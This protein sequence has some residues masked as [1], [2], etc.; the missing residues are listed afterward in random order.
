MKLFPVSL[1]SNQFCKMCGTCARNC[2]Y[3]S[4]HLD[5]RWPGAEIW[6]N[7]E[8]NL[9]TSL[10]IPAFLGILFPLFVHEKLHSHPIGDLSFT[11]IYLASVLG[12]VVLFM[13][14]SLSEGLSNFRSQIRA[15]GFSYLPLA[16]AGHLALLLPY[17]VSG[18]R[19]L[20]SFSLSGEF[21]HE[22]TSPWPQRLILAVGILWSVWALRKLSGARPLIVSSVHGALIIILGLA[23]I[24][25]IGR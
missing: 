21:H 11:L 15:Y 25:L 12:A 22:L 8:P 20:M 24:V 4:I 14:A 10:S 19:R 3:H 17:L 2:P 5:L 16:F 1:T 9:I 23:L 13:A 6:E 18:L 7:K